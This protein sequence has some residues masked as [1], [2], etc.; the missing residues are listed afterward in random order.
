MFM[1]EI[2]EYNRMIDCKNH[3]ECSKCN[4][5]PTYFEEKKRK[6]REERERMKEELREN[7]KKN[8]PLL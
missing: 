1:D 7:A 6:A 3:T 8:S 2:C 4:W 5:N